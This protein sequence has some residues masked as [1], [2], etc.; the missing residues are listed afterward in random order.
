MAP[1]VC[2]LPPGEVTELLTGGFCE[3]L[4]MSTS[5]NLVLDGGLS[6]GHDLAGSRPLG[7]CD[8]HVLP[9]YDGVAALPTRCNRDA[10]VTSSKQ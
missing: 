2:Q 8:P 1:L 7:D 3:P 10:I 6:I 9:D 5:F 4:G